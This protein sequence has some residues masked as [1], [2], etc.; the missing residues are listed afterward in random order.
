MPQFHRTSPTEPPTLRAA[1]P[2]CQ[3]VLPLTEAQMN[4]REGLVCCSDCHGLFNAK[5]HLIEAEPSVGQSQSQGVSEE[6]ATFEAVRPPFQFAPTPAPTPAPSAPSPSAGGCLPRSDPPAGNIP[7]WQPPLPR[8]RPPS[9]AKHNKRDQRVKRAKSAKSAKRNGVEHYLNPHPNP[10]L[11]V[12]WGMVAAGFLVLLGWQAKFFLMERYAQHEDYRRYLVGLCEIAA[13][14]LPPREA[15]SS[16]ALINT[17]VEL[18]PAEPGAIKVTIKLLNEALFT[19]PYPHLRLTFSD[20][21]GR[22]VGRRVFS[23]DSYLQNGRTNLLEAGELGVVWFDLAHPHAQAAG[24][25]VD[26]VT[27]AASS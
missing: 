24:L 26:I 6:A 1:C 9:R 5:W 25:D 23:P 22:V 8:I 7:H 18:H 12:V 4:A 27:S 15:L 2:K 10:L 3:A 20:R 16:L 21:D 17:R 14:E 19:Q 13:C 11:N